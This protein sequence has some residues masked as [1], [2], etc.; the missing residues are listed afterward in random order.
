MNSLCFVVTFL[1]IV[2]TGA[3]QTTELAQQHGLLTTDCKAIRG[4]AKRIVE[5]ASAPELN[6]SVAA[7]HLGEVN[8]SLAS[9][10]K[11]LQGTRKLLTQDRLKLVASE[12]ATLEKICTNLKSFSEKIEKEI[13]KEKPDRLLVKKLAADLRSE[14]MNGSQVHEQVMSKLGIK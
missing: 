5:E 14:M 8:K 13:A 3:A 6:T 12:Y 2:E 10:E 1:I 7:A 9:M 4:H 11:R